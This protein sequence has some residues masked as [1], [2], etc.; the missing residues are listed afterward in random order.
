MADNR[1]I[2]PWTRPRFSV[3]KRR[4]CAA[5]ISVVSPACNNAITIEYN[6]PRQFKMS[7]SGGIKNRITLS[8]AAPG[9][10]RH[11]LSQ[12]NELSSG[13]RDL[14]VNSANFHIAPPNSGH[15][16]TPSP[17]A[18]RRRPRRPRG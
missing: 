14:F 16:T 11:C 8:R 18:E 1:L 7:F 3:I 13:V 5:N 4:L 15:T 10:V 12:D 6:S 9:D 17:T 2:I